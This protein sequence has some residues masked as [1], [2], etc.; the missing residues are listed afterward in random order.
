MLAGLALVASLVMALVAAASASAHTEILLRGGGFPQL[1]LGLSSRESKLV[2]KVPLIGEVTV[3]CPSLLVHGLVRSS[4]DVLLL[5][6]WHRCKDNLGNNC[7]SAG[8]PT[9]LIHDAVL[10]LPKLLLGQVIGFLIQLDLAYNKVHIAEFSCGINKVVVNGTVLG[11]VT[12]PAEG[13][14]SN[15]LKMNI[16][17]KTAGV[18]QKFTHVQGSEEI[19]HLLSSTNGEAFENSTEEVMEAHVH[20]ANPLVTGTIHC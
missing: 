12:S 14:F 8:E 20:F 10:L 11:N 9:G 3:S 19:D 16:E 17:V 5:L 2:T 15:E 7:Q 13:E 4:L 6:L 1:I 18:E